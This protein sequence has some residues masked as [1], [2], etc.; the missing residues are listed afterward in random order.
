MEIKNLNQENLTTANKNFIQK[1]KSIIPQTA[2]ALIVFIIIISYS[3]V[4]L[5]PKPALFF[6][7]GSLYFLF[8]A[9]GPFIFSILIAGIFILSYNLFQK[10]GKIILFSLLTFFFILNI[11][12]YFFGFPKNSFYGYD[13]FS[14]SDCDKIKDSKVTILEE[15]EK[16]LCYLEIA[17]RDNDIKI[18]DRIELEETKGRC[19]WSIARNQ[20][21]PNYCLEAKDKNYCYIFYA[22]KEARRS[23]IDDGIA[24]CKMIMDYEIKKFCCDS[25]FQGSET[26][27]NKECLKK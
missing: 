10:R 7:P 3:R 1:F 12:F 19:F 18:C 2:I 24:V 13:T 23:S 4:I 17:R 5:P 8:I 21:S 11:P 27:K 22:V 25:I 9:I 14:V 6:A 20:D 26:D 16:D 15:K